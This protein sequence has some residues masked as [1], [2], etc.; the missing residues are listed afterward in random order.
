[1]VHS[2]AARLFAVTPHASNR[3]W[4]AALSAYGWSRGAPNHAD[5]V[6]RDNNLRGGIINV[7]A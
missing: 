6:H 5:Y 4:T 1:M 7:A 3:V 2:G